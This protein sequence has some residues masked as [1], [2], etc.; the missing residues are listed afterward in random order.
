MR[1]QRLQRVR[2]H[3]ATDH[4]AAPAVVQLGHVARRSDRGGPLI[5]RGVG[6]GQGRELADRRL[7]LEHDLQPALGYLGLIGRVGGEEL[8]ALAQHVHE[9]GHVVVVEA[10]AQKA[11]LLLGAG[12]ALGQRA[13]MLVDLL[14]G[15]AVGQRQRPVQAYSRRDLAV[16]DLLHRGHPDG[17]QHGGEIRGCDGGVATQVAR[18]SL[19]AHWGGIGGRVHQRVALGGIA[20]AHSH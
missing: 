15:E 9:R 17:L 14:L 6:H 11:Q 19:S 7:V 16:E 8:G 3:A 12:V 20:E 10:G 1:A 4:Q 5:D 13:Q 18:L 2:M